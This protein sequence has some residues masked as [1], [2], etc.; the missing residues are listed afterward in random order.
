MSEG[1]RLYDAARAALSRD[2]LT[3]EAQTKIALFL[4]AAKAINAAMLAPH[5][6]APSTSVAYPFLHGQWFREIEFASLL[7]RVTRWTPNP[8]VYFEGTT[9]VAPLW[10]E[11]CRIQLGG[12]GLFEPRSIYAALAF[13][14]ALLARVRLAPVLADDGEKLDPFVVAIRRIEQESSRMIQIQI[15]LL[16]D[17]D[18]PLAVDER[19]RIVEDEQAIVD[20]AFRR[21]LQ[22]LA[23]APRG[24]PTSNAAG[25]AVG[26]LARATLAADEAASRARGDHFRAA[27][28]AIVVPQP[29]ATPEITSKEDERNAN[30]HTGIGRRAHS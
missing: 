26:P 13:G 7:A 4:G 29:T 16:K 11:W 14:H 10:Q 27:A 28:D 17:A 25:E 18:V 12:A 22:W 6:L 24:A 8:L 9:L 21:F 15:R 20:E 1:A 30:D 3:A 19:E 5:E 23:G 2:G